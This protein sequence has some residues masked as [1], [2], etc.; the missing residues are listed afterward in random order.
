MIKTTRSRLW[1]EVNLS[2]LGGDHGRRVFPSDA[3]PFALDEHFI[4]P[5][6]LVEMI[7]VPGEIVAAMFESFGP[8]ERTFGQ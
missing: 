6:L 7:H 3:L 2:V 8:L 1:Q 5:G 4:S